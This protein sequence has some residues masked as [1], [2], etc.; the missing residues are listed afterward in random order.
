MVTGNRWIEVYLDAI[1][2]NYRVIRAQLKENVRFCAVVKAD[3][4]GLGA[5]RIAMLLQELEVDMLAVTTVDEGLELRKSGIRIPILVMSPFLEDEAAIFLK[6]NLIPVVSYKEQLSWLAQA[7]EQ[8]GHLKIHLKLETGM[9]RSG[10]AEREIAEFLF[11]LEKYPQ[12]QVSGLM[13]HLSKAHRNSR[14]MADQLKKYDELCQHFTFLDKDIIKHVGNSAVALEVPKAQYNM[15]RIGTLLY[16]QYPPNTKLKLELQNPW[17]GKA[18]V[19]QRKSCPRGET[20]GY[21]D[22]FLAKQELE[23]AVVP[24]GWADGLGIRPQRAVTS[25][26]EAVKQSLKI[27]Q[28]FF[29][30]ERV[31]IEIN[32]RSY[33]QV[34]R[35]TMQMSIFQVDQEVSVGQIAN[36]PLSRLTASS[37][38]PRIYIENQEVISRREVIS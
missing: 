3:A 16:G 24:I 29:K 36:I 32:G 21:G 27:W 17:Q 31:R 35:L 30:R 4:Y 1:I 23:L 6:H 26:R 37:R 2:H 14:S 25:W 5:V 11:D 22:D 33:A 12:L 9:H 20:I 18:R 13:T 7:C 28:S 10:I 38:L 15:V 8:D 34:G 19:I